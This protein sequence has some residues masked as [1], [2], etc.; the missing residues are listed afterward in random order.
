MERI[1]IFSQQK[2][3][4]TQI[5]DAISKLEPESELLCFTDPIDSLSFTAESPSL[6]GAVIDIDSDA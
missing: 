5:S 1:L 4:I 6:S 3:L 2:L